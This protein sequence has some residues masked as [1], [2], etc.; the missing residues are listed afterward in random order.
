MDRR[1]RARDQLPL[2]QGS[3]KP[4]FRIRVT[5][6]AGGPDQAYLNGS[7]LRLMDQTGNSVSASNGSET[8]LRPVILVGLGLGTT[9]LAAALVLWAYFG[10]AVFYEM[11]LAGIAS[12]F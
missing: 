5:G 8:M 1:L 4:G 7:G 10:S 6:V 11:I 9:L 12:C 2:S 3:Q